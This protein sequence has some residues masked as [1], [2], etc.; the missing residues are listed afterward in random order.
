[1]LGP[2]SDCLWSV[3]GVMLNVTRTID[4]DP[5]VLKA[6]VDSRAKNAGRDV[7]ATEAGIGDAAVSVQDRYGRS[8]TI[9]FARAGPRRS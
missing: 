9:A 5:A 3:P 4:N 8:I 7:V 6:V 2:E 1:M